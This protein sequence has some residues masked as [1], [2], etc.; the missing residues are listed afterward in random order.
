MKTLRQLKEEIHQ[1]YSHLHVFDIDDTLFHPTAKVNVVDNAG[2]KVK[3]L[4]SKEYAHHSTHNLLKSTEKYDFTEFRNAKKFKQESNPI[5][6]TLNLVK[7]L[8]KSPHNHIILNTARV[9]M[10]NKNTFLNTFKAHGLNMNKIHIIR[11]GNIN[12]PVSSDMK[13][14][15]V[16]R[17]Y[18]NKHKYKH[19]HMYD[20]DTKNLSTFKDLKHDYP[21]TNFYAHHVQHTG[22][23]KDF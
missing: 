9:N 14:A 3:S 22:E 15:T 16:I 7:S 6:S 2:N 13:K 10:D 18:I 12:A 19:V 1:K 8:Q 11:A 23:L 4:S 17:G 20:D 5:H 21:N